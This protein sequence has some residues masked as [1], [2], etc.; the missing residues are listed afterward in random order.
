MKV[1]DVKAQNGQTLAAGLT[2]REA[3]ALARQVGG[4]VRPRVIEAPVR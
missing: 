1:F 3:N 4:F 2:L